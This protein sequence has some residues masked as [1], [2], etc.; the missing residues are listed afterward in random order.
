MHIPHRRF[1]AITSFTKESAP[2]D[3]PKLTAIDALVSSSTVHA[4][5][6]AAAVAA[7]VD[8]GCEAQP[9]AH[10]FASDADVQ[11]IKH[12]LHAGLDAITAV[13]PAAGPA[14]LAETSTS[15]AIE[16]AA[17]ITQI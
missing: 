10:D 13:T 14:A 5:A 4:D 2:P 15:S 16:H 7:A 11:L 17:A 9:M 8:A 1:V 12:A 6:T 3:P